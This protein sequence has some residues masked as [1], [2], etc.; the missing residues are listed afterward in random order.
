ML[1][2]CGGWVSD[3]PVNAESPPEQAGEMT[4]ETGGEGG[5][6]Q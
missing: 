4:N 6:F 3:C 1:G 5:G 2:R